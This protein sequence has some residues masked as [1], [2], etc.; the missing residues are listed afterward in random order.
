MNDREQEAELCRNF[1]CLEYD[2]LLS[3]SEAV[4]LYTECKLQI[5]DYLRQGIH[6]ENFFELEKKFD[7]I[8]RS[9]KYESEKI[10][11]AQ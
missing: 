2:R 6:Y 10:E 3:L 1:S 4:L 11:A 9:L 7:L 5:V 8:E